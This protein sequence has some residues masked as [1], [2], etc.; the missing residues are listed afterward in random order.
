MKGGRSKIL[1]ILSTQFMNVPQNDNLGFHLFYLCASLLKAHRKQHLKNLAKILFWEL[2][3]ASF[4]AP[5]NLI[6]SSY[7]QKL[8]AIHYIP[9]QTLGNCVF[10]LIG[11]FEKALLYIQYVHCVQNVFLRMTLC[12]RITLNTGNVGGPDYLKLGTFFPIP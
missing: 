2:Q 1:K 9:S 10:F 6:F 12:S 7:T 8:L 11:V 4:C 5:C 3:T